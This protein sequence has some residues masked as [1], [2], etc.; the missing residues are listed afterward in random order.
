MIN[1]KYKGKEILSH[2]NIPKDAVAIVY[3]LSYDDSTKYIGYK[4]VR[5]KRRLKPTKKQLAVRKNYKRVEMVDLPFLKY[6][7]SSRE[8][9]GKVLVRKEILYFTSN[10]R[11]AT[12]LETK[13]LFEHNVLFDDKFNN[14][15]ISGRFFDT[16]MDGLIC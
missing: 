2:S 15:N 13:L 4:L 1:W 7:G 6:V 11:T 8:N 9:K 5:S 12:Y 16:A 10:K 14:K 3:I